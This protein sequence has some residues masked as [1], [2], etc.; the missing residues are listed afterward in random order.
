MSYQHLVMALHQGERD[1]VPF[2][3]GGS[4]VTGIHVRVLTV[5]RRVLGLS[6]EAQVLDRVTQM[7]DTGDDVRDRLH[8]DVREAERDPDPAPQP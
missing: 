5:L 7:A 4:T 8:V 2:D 6:S 3:L 1:R